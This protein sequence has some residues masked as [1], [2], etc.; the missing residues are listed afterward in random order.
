MSVIGGTFTK[1]AEK[2]AGDE[3]SSRLRVTS[4]I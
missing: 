2:V 1:E 4:D 3:I